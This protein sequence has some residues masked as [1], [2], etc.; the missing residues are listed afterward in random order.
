MTTSGWRFSCDVCGRFISVEDLVSGA[1]LHKLLT[2]DS[3]F[4]METYE[5]LC[6]EHKT[7]VTHD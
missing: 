1:A 3:E 6:Q 7:E 5:T 2:P 4:T